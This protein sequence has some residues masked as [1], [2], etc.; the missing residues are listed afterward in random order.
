MK[1]DHIKDIYLHFRKRYFKN[2]KKR[3]GHNAIEKDSQRKFYSRKIEDSHLQER[4]INYYPQKLPSTVSV[5][6]GFWSTAL[7]RCHL[8]TMSHHSARAE[9]L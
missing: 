2:N 7:L 1:N 5:N 9:K 4:S 8:W 3:R 6:E